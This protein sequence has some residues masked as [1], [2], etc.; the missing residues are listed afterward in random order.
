MNVSENNTTNQNV[1]IT[2]KN[3]KYNF[4][5]IH[6][7]ETLKN[8]SIVFSENTS[9][10]TV[11]PIN[12]NKTNVDYLEKKY[13][14]IIDN[15]QKYYIDFCKLVEIRNKLNTTR[16]EFGSKLFVNKNG[17]ISS[18]KK[19][20]FINSDDGYPAMPKKIKINFNNTENKTHSETET[21]TE[22]KT[23]IS[24]GNDL[25]N[26]EIYK[27]Y[28]NNLIKKFKDKLTTNNFEI[29][30]N[31]NIFNLLIII[32]KKPEMLQY[33]IDNNENI[34]RYI[35]PVI[36]NENIYTPLILAVKFKNLEMV[37][38]LINKYNTQ[39]T[40]NISWLNKDTNS[41][42]VFASFDDGLSDSSKIYKLLITYKKK[43]KKDISP[44][45]RE[46]FSKYIPIALH[47]LYSITN[48]ESFKS[49][50][51]NYEKYLDYNQNYNNKD[52][53]IEEMK[54]LL[55]FKKDNIFYYIK[56]KKINRK[57]KEQTLY[58]L[59]DNKVLYD[60]HHGEY[61]N[62]KRNRPFYI[63]RMKEHI[64]IRDYICTLLKKYRVV[65]LFCRELF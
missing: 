5:N 17:D 16:S 11:V 51:T 25:L 44:A 65:R 50:I 12:T 3:K 4:S 10:N 55:T 2:K 35:F 64:K 47:V 63:H 52:N 7:R 54:K 24:I 39:E 23:Y 58:E 26:N 1:N 34:S 29:F 46:S 30:I 18:I 6:I 19:L 60:N 14:L 9:N 41:A 31:I 37:K 56:E 15:N 36:N 21:E 32:N 8:N 22:T 27:D 13:D 53:K 20:R 38:I 48:F 42:L 43:Y 57:M 40:T 59:H 33:I 61:A 49:I 62:E 28:K 45:Y